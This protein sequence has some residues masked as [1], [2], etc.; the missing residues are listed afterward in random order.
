MMTMTQRFYSVTEA[1]A[2]LGITKT[3]FLQRRPQPVP[4][5]MIGKVRGWTEQTLRE[6]NQTPAPKGGAPRRPIPEEPTTV[7][8]DM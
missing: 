3:T 5:A 4:D 8:R 2:F 7:D 6:W 1:A